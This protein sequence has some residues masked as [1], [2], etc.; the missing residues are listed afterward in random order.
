M[1]TEDEM[2]KQKYLKY[3]RKYLQLKEQEG[4]IM[5]QDDHYIFF[6]KKVVLDNTEFKNINKESLISANDFTDRIGNCSWYLPL[7]GFNMVTNLTLTN[8]YSTIKS[9]FGL[10]KSLAK[11]IGKG[12]GKTVDAVGFVGSTLLSPFSYAKKAYDKTCVSQDCQSKKAQKGGSDDYLFFPDTP[13][14]V[15]DKP[16]N[17]IKLDKKYQAKEV[18]PKFTDIAQELLKKINE[19]VDESSKVDTALLIHITLA[20]KLTASNRVLDIHHLTK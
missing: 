2:Y 14:G 6:Y 16:Q 13:C 11:G 19:K 4:G 3:K 1:N 7:Q 12:I 10:A 20:K 5:Y 9:N 18:I 17:D 8:R 15:L